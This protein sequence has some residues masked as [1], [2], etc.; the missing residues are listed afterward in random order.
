MNRLFILLL[1]GLP[2]ALPAQG[3]IWITSCTDQT[4]CLN[5]GSCN[6]GSVFLVEKAFTSCGNSNISYSYRIDLNNDGSQDIFSTE[7]T[8]QGN[9]APGT[10]KAIWRATDFCGNQI[11]CSYLFT[12][13]DCFPPSLICI[14]GL[15]QNLDPPN[16]SEEFFASQFILSMS[17][18]CTPTNEIEYGIREIGT[19]MGFPPDTLIRFD[20]CDIGTRFVEIWVRD[21][22]GLFNSCQGYVLLQNGGNG[23]SCDI[24]AGISFDGCAES[25]GGLAMSQFRLRAAVTDS[26]DSWQE[27]LLVEDSCYSLLVEGMPFGGD[28]AASVWATRNEGPLV[29]FSTFDLFLISKHILGI[30]SFTSFYQ[31]MAADM[32][33]S[34]SVTT[35]DI[36]EGRKLLLGIYDTFPA[37]PS[38]RMIKPLAN[39]AN[40]DQWGLV[41]YTYQL[42]YPSLISDLTEPNMRFVGVKSGDVN[43]SASLIG[44]DDRSGSA[45]PIWFE[46]RWVA[47]GQIIE[48]PFSFEKTP[49]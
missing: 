10:H 43:L 27:T 13:Q 42:D 15:T 11:E 6:E 12:I 9:F 31:M 44:S 33:N 32:N 18:N 20:S 23:C 24:D 29:G 40:L 36:V 14:N 1:V 45:I 19:G 38:W 2:I 28:Y 47:E 49:I 41:E 8:I 34:Q 4:F 35:F 26:I 17:D 37:V 22:D 5:Q 25:A 21:A 7:D 39:P 16:C 48:I 46:D 30:E 3:L